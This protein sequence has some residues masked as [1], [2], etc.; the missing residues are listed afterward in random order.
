[1]SVFCFWVCVWVCYWDVKFDCV[2]YVDVVDCGIYYNRSV[3]I[4]NVNC[5]VCWFGVV[6]GISNKICVVDFYLY[7]G[8]IGILEFMVFEL[9]E[10]EYNEL[11]DI[12]LFGMCL[13]EM[14]IFEYSYSECI[15]VV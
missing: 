10:E 8:F 6:V 14:V 11:V 3:L 1:M 13:L 4:F 7:I 9:Y 15:N 12:Y 2:V 5:L